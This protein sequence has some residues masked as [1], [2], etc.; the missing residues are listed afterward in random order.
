MKS[1]QQR[2]R[3]YEQKLRELTSPAHQGEMT[4]EV[5]AILID[6]CTAAIVQ[7]KQEI[8]EEAI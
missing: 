7:I 4:P 3:E 5:R 6:T 8:Q 1:L 2:L